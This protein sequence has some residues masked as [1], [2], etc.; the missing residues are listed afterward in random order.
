MLEEIGEYIGEGISWLGEA[1][2]SLVPSNWDSG[3]WSVFLIVW[4]GI[5]IYVWFF[6]YFYDLSG[7]G[8]IRYP[9]LWR[10]IIVIGTA[11]IVMFFVNQQGR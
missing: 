4:G 3:H 1:I 9:L 11:P 2:V 8:V 6:G 7:G 5:S 10:A